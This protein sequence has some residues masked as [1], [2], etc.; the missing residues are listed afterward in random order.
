MASSL[1]PSFKI[2]RFFAQ[3]EFNTPYLLCCSDAESMPMSDLVALA[4]Q[5]SASLWNDLALGYTQ[6]SGHPL[7]KQEIARLHGIHEKD[8]LVL[9]PQEGIYIAM[10]CLASLLKTYDN[11]NWVI[12][13]FG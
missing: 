2:E 11:H 7:L 12:W 4:D 13:N 6:S 1:P 8:V 5:G 3:Y 9:T 10:K